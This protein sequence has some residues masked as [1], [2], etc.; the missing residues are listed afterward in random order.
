MAHRMF[1]PDPAGRIASQVGKFGIGMSIDIGLASLV[2]P[3]AGESGG[4][5][6]RWR[7]N[8]TVQV[9]K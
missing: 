4:H 5:E 7:E 1:V 3:R 6:A 8:I 9:Q 2:K